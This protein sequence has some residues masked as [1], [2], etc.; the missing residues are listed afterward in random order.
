MDKMKKISVK[1]KFEIGAD[2]RFTLIAGPCAIE[3]EEMSLDVAVV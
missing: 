1:N 2:K 3:N